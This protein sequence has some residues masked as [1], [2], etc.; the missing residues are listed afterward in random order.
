MRQFAR[1]VN[2]K[3][4]W[5]SVLLCIAGTVVVGLLVSQLPHVKVTTAETMYDV[6]LGIVVCNM[7]FVGFAAMLALKIR[8]QVSEAYL[9]AMSWL[10]AAFVV[11]VF[12][13]L[14]FL[15][16]QLTMTDG[17]WYFDYSFSIIPFVV[18]A[19]LFVRAGYE[20]NKIGYRLGEVYVDK[21]APAGF[22]KAVPASALDI[23]MYMAGLA[24]NPRAV[25]PILDEVRQVTAQLGPER[26]LSAAD[27]VVMAKVYKQ[28]EAYLAE[29]E[30]L[31]VFTK[32]GLRE[33]IIQKF[34]ESNLATIE[35][36]TN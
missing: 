26:A 36:L 2:V 22:R 14:H 9:P 3:S 16:V 8:A 27:K 24:S 32:E 31:R 29:K 5:S 20:F 35:F 17:A 4:L 18:G 23:V 11:L 34:G 30:A 1:L 28:L 6:L 10:A 33:N 21:P 25:N 13:G 12:A 19:L 7:F 15:V